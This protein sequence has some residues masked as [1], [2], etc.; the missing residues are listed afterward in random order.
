V[1]ELELDNGE[2]ITATADHPV[3]TAAGWKTVGELTV[4]DD[5]LCVSSF[6]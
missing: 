2:K 1:F 3:L 4:S 6:L 5:I